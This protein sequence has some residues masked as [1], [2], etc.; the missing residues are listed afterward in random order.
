MENLGVDPKLLLAQLIN[1][2]LFFLLFSKFIAKPFMQY[3][4]SEKKK[5]M[6]RQRVSELALKQEEELE[7]HKRKISDKMKKEFDV[8]IQD[9]RKDA[10]ELKKE[11]IKEAKKEAEAVVSKAQEEMKVARELMEREMKEKVT[12]LSLILVS[13]VLKDYL[14]EDMQKN[15]TARLI[16]NLSQSKQPLNEN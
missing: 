10:L 2:G 5:D 14:N 9:A 4:E 13:K 8:A 3:I 15:I 6:E 1:F 12:S 11:L 16:N 7:A